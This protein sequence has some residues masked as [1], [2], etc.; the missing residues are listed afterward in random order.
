M[1]GAVEGDAGKVRSNGLK[2]VAHFTVTNVIRG[3][4]KDDESKPGFF[5][6]WYMNAWPEELLGKRPAPD[7]TDLVS[8]DASGKVLIDHHYVQY[9]SLCVN[10]PATR[11]ML[12]QMARAA[13]GNGV[14]GFMTTYNYRRACACVHCQEAFRAHL[15]GTF[16]P[17]EI[18]RHF[19]IA[20]IDR[21]KFERIPGQTPGYPADGECD[22]LTLASFQ[23]SA[24]AY[25]AAWDEIFLGE[26]RG[27]K[28]DLILGQW[29]HLGNVAVTEERGFLPISSFAKG[30]NYLWYSGNHYN[31]DAKPGDDNDGWLNGLYLRALAGD[32]PYVMGRYDS[33]RIRVGQ[34]EAMAWGGLAPG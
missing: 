21:A 10:N 32:K 12:K 29:D 3:P 8:K 1:L 33:V 2:S 7:W 13:L 23:W 9:N 11:T 25:K 28:P 30:E 15:K 34:A 14:D 19:G 5:A 22:P 20:D 17:Q 4:E 16:S 26:G 18:Q 27:A 24:L 31:P 6:D